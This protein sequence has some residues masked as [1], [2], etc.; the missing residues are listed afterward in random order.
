MATLERVAKA[1]ITNL[2]G[3]REGWWITHGSRHGVGLLN[4]RVETRAIVGG[5]RLL[6]KVALKPRAATASIVA[7]GYN[8]A[9]EKVVLTLD[10]GGVLLLTVG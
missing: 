4:R 7:A 3:C 10:D 5:D 6:A 8:T 2:P 1:I 9:S